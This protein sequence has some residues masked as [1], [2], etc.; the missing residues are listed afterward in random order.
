MIRILCLTRKRGAFTDRS[1]LF[2]IQAGRTVFSHGLFSVLCMFFFWTGSATASVSMETGASPPVI[3]AT[4]HDAPDAGTER[5]NPG[6]MRV[7]PPVPPSDPGD[8]PVQVLIVP[9]GG[10]N[11][12]HSFSRPGRHSSGAGSSRR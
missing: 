7:Q 6:E 1:T 5:L 3:L 11:Q 8:V 9:E 4:P 2:S 12:H 10:W